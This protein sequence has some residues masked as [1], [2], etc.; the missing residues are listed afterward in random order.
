MLRNARQALLGQLCIDDS[1][2]AVGW[3]HNLVPSSEQPSVVSTTYGL[4]ALA[5]L[6]GPDARTP[7]IV[8]HV[9]KAGVRADGTITGWKAS[10]QSEPRLEATARAV[11]SLLRAGVPLKVDKV[12]EVIER[13]LDETSARAPVH[14]DPRG[15]AAAPH[16]TRLPPHR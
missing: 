7:D 1:G 4:G 8:E 6:G 16:R 15:R 10:V 5:L 14:P 3:R 13:L 2:R 11:E 12:V 9:M